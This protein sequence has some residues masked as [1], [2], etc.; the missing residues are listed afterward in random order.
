MQAISKDW[1]SDDQH[2]IRILQSV[3]EP[4]FARYSQNAHPYFDDFE[5]G[6]ML[7]VLA[8]GLPFDSVQ[9]ALRMLVKNLLA[10]DT[11][12]YHFE[13]QVYTSDGQT[14]NVHNAI[15]ATILFFAML[16]NRDPA[17]AE[18]LKSTRPELQTALEYAKEGRQRSL[19]FGPVTRPQTNQSPTPDPKRRI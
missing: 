11:R 12:K 4:A 19:G 8:G 9:P 17:L 3:F 14:A 13:A 5:F 7:Q 18:E 1:G 10:T 16:I 6:E 2:A 15:D